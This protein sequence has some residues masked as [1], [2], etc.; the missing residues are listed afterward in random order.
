MLS[1]LGFLHHC[2][3]IPTDLKPENVLL[4]APLSDPPP[5]GKTMYDVVQESINSNPEVQELQRQCENDELSSEERQRLR[6][7]LRKLRSK[8]KKSGGRW[9]A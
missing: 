1:G 7:K 8:I 2:G 3:I 6:A 4:K 9:G 5:G